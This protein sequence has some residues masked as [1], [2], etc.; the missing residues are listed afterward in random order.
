MAIYELTDRVQRAG[1]IVRQPGKTYLHESF[2]ILALL[3]LVQIALRHPPFKHHG[4]EA[5]NK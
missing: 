3:D 4:E 5:I 2:L 1:A